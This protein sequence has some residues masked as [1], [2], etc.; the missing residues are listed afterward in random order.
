MTAAS[1]SEGTA[2]EGAAPEHIEFFFDPMCPWAYQTSVWIR[3][4]RDRVGLDITWRFFSLEEINRVEGKKHPWEREWSYGWSQMR[5]ASLL[6][7]EGQ[8]LVDRWYAAAGR[9]FHLEGRKTHVPDVHRQ[10]LVELDLD[11]G[12]VD[13]AIAD[14]TTTDEVRADHDHAVGHH[15]AYGAP[16]IVLPGDHAVFGPVITPAPTGS[17]SVRLWSLVRGWSEFPHL[18]ELVH[19][20]TADDRRHIAESFTP[21]LRSRDW[22]TIENPAP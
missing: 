14:P 13:A 17:A 20:K 16:T 2:P 6:R 10:L 19:P 22:N 11:P 1:K 4:V 18:Y 5:I 21:Y 12:L 15:G 9:A 3:E 8:D 7:R